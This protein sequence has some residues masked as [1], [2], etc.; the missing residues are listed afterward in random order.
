M[1]A[2]FSKEISKFIHQ[3]PAAVLSDGK[4]A[5]RIVVDLPT[6]NAN[7]PNFAMDN[8]TVLSVKK[9]GGD[10]RRWIIEVMPEINTW[11]ATLNIIAGEESFEYP[12]TVAPP[13]GSS[14]KADQNGWNHFL[15]SG[16]TSKKMLYDFNK[17]GVQDYIDEFIFIAN[18][19]ASK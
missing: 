15:N 18:H 5:I 12:L 13:L 16:K 2:L 6:R 10:N 14:I 11:K 9:E 19:L 3:E 8:A 1:V 7:S 17:D 4:T